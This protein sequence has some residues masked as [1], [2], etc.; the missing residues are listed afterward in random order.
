MGTTDEASVFQYALT[1]SSTGLNDQWALVKE[2]PLQV[3][4]SNDQKRSFTP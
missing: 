3:M 2:L 4:I 1:K